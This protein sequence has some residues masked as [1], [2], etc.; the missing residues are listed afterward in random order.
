MENPVET[1][2][3]LQHDDSCEGVVEYHPTLPT[4]YSRDGAFIVFP[5]CAKHY[6]QYVASYEA[7]ERREEEAR[8]RQYCKH[9]TFIG[10]PYGPDYMCGKCEDGQ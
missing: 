8:R 5:R 10:D 9:G 2:T 6:G 1:L 3:C 4:R 7:R